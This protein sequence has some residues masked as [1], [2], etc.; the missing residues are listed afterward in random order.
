MAH[1]KSLPVLLCSMIALACGGTSPSQ[2]E[3]SEPPPEGP[4]P[5]IAQIDGPTW[6]ELPVDSSF[7][8]TYSAAQ[9]TGPIVRYQWFVGG[10]S[11]PFAEGVTANRT[12]D[13]S[14]RFV[15]RLRVEG[16]EG[17][18]D[19]ANLQTFVWFDLTRGGPVPGFHSVHRGEKPSLVYMHPTK[20]DVQIAL[21]ASDEFWGGAVVGASWSPDFSRLVFSDYW[22]L[23]IVNRDGTGLRRLDLGGSESE[24]DWSPTGEWIAY[25][26][27]GQVPALLYLIRPGGTGQTLVGDWDVDWP[28]WDPSGTRIAAHSPWDGWF[29]ISIFSDL[30]G[31]AQRERLHTEDQL[32][33]AFGTTTYLDEGAN[34]VAWSPG[35]EWIAYTAIVTTTGGG[36]ELITEHKLVTARADGSGDIRI[37]VTGDESSVLSHPTWSPDGETIYFNRLVASGFHIFSIPAAGGTATDLSA[38]TDADADDHS[39]FFAR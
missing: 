34:G 25:H 37:L 23:W 14:G 6:V 33:A 10:S 29:R 7:P 4:E 8:A 38:F 11:E 35:G 36:G 26:K 39:P 17:Q 28:S 21:E 2:P 31:A 32:E 27:A 19:E 13:T 1:P 9:S 30:W 24:P 3:D 15:T 20:G 12:F 5:V 22:D 18:S 16:D